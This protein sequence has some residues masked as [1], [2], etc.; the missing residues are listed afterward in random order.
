[1]MLRI[2]TRQIQAVISP[3]REWCRFGVRDPVVLT[4]ETGRPL[5]ENDR[6]TVFFNGRDRPME[7]GGITRVGRA[8]CSA[9]GA[10]WQVADSPV[11]DDGDYCALGSAVRRDDEYWIY[12][13][14]GTRD[15]FRVARSIDGKH[16]RREE[17]LLLTP[18]QFNC[19]RIGLPFVF[20]PSGRWLMLFEGLRHHRFRIY[21]AHSDDG[22]HWVPSAGEPVFMPDDQA[23]D[24][25]AQA[26]PSVFP[27]DD[28]S[29]CILF[30]NGSAVEEPQGWE[31]AATS[32]Q[33]KPRPASSPFLSRDQASL[34]GGRLEGTRG[35]APQADGVLALYFALPGNDSYKDGAI[36][37]AKLEDAP[38]NAQL[39][40][41]ERANDRLA[42]TYFDIWDR[43]PIQVFTQK[44]E[45]GW[46][47]EQVSPGDRVLL[48]GSGGA[49][50]LPALL[51]KGAR[52]I[53]LDLSQ[54]MLD[55]GK[56]RFAEAEVTWRRGDVCNLPEDI[57]SM[58]AIYALG[59]VFAYVDSLDCALRSCRT[60]L[61]P[62]G[63]L[64]FTI[65]NADHPTEAPE[66]TTWPDGRVRQARTLDDL[67]ARIAAAGLE[68]VEARGYRF[69]VD[70]LPAQWNRAV[71][72]SGAPSEIL[73]RLLELEEDMLGLLPVERAK[74]LWIH[75]KAG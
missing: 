12:Y 41:E 22:F 73:T 48:A 23:W 62:G 28:N 58:D 26:N 50:E 61:R 64:I 55:A 56:A 13:S 65:M 6:L 21:Q 52:V 16:W 14:P 54:K 20:R 19:S 70:L 25:Y 30:Y 40:S 71:D 59:G 27:R 63:N 38:L 44:L 33:E 42:D 67:K 72:T 45:S 2:G 39:E 46:L 75:A 18:G 31:I 3:D 53:A 5:L 35:L 29:S 4:D 47:A 43:Y 66:R 51:D 1:M 11:L 24:G 60:A 7:E 37:L 74:F 15:G 68:F 10:G 57:A 49:R 69:L 32:W 9:D 34:P 8:L 36:Y 17:R